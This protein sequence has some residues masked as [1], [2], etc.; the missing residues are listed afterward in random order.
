[1]TQIDRRRFLALAGAAAAGSLGGPALFAT[2][3]RAA[4]G[5]SLTVAWPAPPPG[6]D[7]T[8][9]PGARDR[10]AQS[11]WK[12]VFDQYLDRKPDLALGPG[13]LSA[14]G[15]NAERSRVYMTLRKAAMWQ[16]GTP[17]EPKDIVW[18]LERLAKP[19]TGCPARHVWAS[20][21]DFT[22]DGDTVSAAVRH[23]TPDFFDWLGYHT[24]YMLPP[25]YYREVGAKGFARKP[26]GAGP[27]R[28]VETG[29]KGADGSA[30][31]RLEAF[32]GHY[33]PKPAFGTVEFR[34]VGDPQSRAEAVVRG[35]VDL[36]TELDFADFDRLKRREGVVGL[37]R[38]LTAT[39]MLVLNDTGPMKDP[40]VRRAAQHAIFKQAIVDH[41]LRG[42]GVPADQIEPPGS[43]GHIP[44]LR[45]P[46]DPARAVDLLSRSG[47]STG[48]PVRFTVQTTRGHWPMD[49]ETVEAI[50]GM[51]Q[52][53]GISAAIEVIPA[54][55]LTARAAKDDLAPACFRVWDNAS[56][57]PNN[58]TGALLWG[59]SPNSVWDSDDLDR[60]LKPLMWGK[61]DAAA[62][63]NGW[64]D[65]GRYIADNALVLP[66]FRYATRILHDRNLVI[67]PGAG[68]CV[69]PSLV[70][71]R[72]A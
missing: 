59:P 43:F 22:V 57:D 12:S 39:A 27:Y 32:E 20:V 51:W 11:I 67:A 36:A 52:H 30:F 31:L 66:I 18:N 13:L 8:T 46:Y 25:R 48:K 40:N 54:R 5:D 29:G 17:I 4:S 2:R 53:V 58:G 14:W 24:G 65:V 70:G 6:W 45:V 35:E 26:V 19:R 38:P 37:A 72:E 10:L 63:A 28:V 41:L 64:R 15:W 21:A 33:G 34:F 50:V 23:Y 16:D 9:G 42:C 55:E 44:S 60:R 68:G 62:R 7:P 71:R 69:L 61:K 56:G 47:Y 3:A 1:M 49:F